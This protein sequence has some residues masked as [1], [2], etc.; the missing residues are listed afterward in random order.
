MKKTTLFK[1]LLA[2]T[3]A[4][5]GSKSFA[6]NYVQITS[7][8]ELTTGSYVVVGGTSSNA[9]STTQNTKGTFYMK[10]EAVTVDG[11]KIV[12]PSTS[13]IWTITKDD[14]NGT[15]SFSANGKYV[16]S[17]GDANSSKLIDAI[18]NTAQYN[19]TFEDGKFKFA[20]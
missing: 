12:D 5:A 19:A 14:S 8:D 15:F 3:I 6:D 16:S 11:D 13:V 18:A 9:M 17:N 1:S 10:I 2:M 20:C 7:I 4:F